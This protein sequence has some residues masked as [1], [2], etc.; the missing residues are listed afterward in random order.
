MRKKYVLDQSAVFDDI[1]RVLGYF[2][3]LVCA[4][5]GP[6]GRNIMLHTEDGL[7]IITKDG[8]TVAEAIDFDDKVTYK[9]I[10][11]IIKESARRTNLLAGDGTTTS[12]VITIATVL[13]IQAARKQYPLDEIRKEILHYRNDILD[14]LKDMRKQISKQDDEEKLKDMLY[15]IAMI[16]TNGDEEISKNISEVVLQAGVDGLI[17]TKNT[18][19]KISWESAEG[20]KIPNAH[21]AHAEFVRGTPDQTLKLKKVHILLTN[22]E[23]EDG[24]LLHILNENILKEIKIKGQSL[25]IVAKSGKSFLENM[26]KFNATGQLNNCIVNPPYFGDVGRDMLDDLAA[27]TGATILDVNKGHQLSALKMQHLGYAEEA[28]ITKEHTTLY[29]PNMIPEEVDKR[30]KILEKAKETLV[31]GMRDDRKIKERL[32]ALKGNVYT[33]NITKISNIED[34]ERLDRVEDAINACKGALEHGYLPGGGLALIYAYKKFSQRTTPALIQDIFSK[35][36]YASFTQ[37]LRNMD[38]VDPE[39]IL[40]EYKLDNHNRALN[41]REMEVGDPIEVGAIDSYKVISTAFQNGVSIG[42]TLSTC[43]G[44]IANDPEKVPYQ[45]FEFGY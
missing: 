32:A 11:D 35:I 10:A 43:N 20:I 25:L 39:K 38:I 13:A 12:I 3:S 8:V 30:I 36:C 9:V 24:D 7:P 14:I 42:L 1:Q 28:V 17:T 41:L 40:R 33:L 23:L 19:G 18:Y 16:S 15:K 34:G 29:K 21:F 45:P 26:I 27:Y 2:E 5:M 31:P 44:I 4:T 6:E 22:M 37:I